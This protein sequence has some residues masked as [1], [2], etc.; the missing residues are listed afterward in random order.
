[1]KTKEL[2]ATLKKCPEESEVYFDDLNGWLLK[3]SEVIVLSPI[4]LLKYGKKSAI[5]A[6]KLSD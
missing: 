3:V 2:I 1:M 4:K 5:S 6:V